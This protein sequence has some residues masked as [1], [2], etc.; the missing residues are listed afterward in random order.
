MK[1]ESF[2]T[3]LK[4]TPKYYDDS[5]FSKMKL[6]GNRGHF[7]PEQ[8]ISNRYAPYNEGINM[9]MNDDLREY[10]NNYQNNYRNFGNQVYDNN[11]NLPNNQLPTPY[12]VD[13]FSI[14]GEQEK[15][16]KMVPQNQFSGTFGNPPQKEYI[17]N[18]MSNDT[19]YHYR[20]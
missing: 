14:Q 7:Y 3:P 12:Q 11:Y 17:P 1:S 4:V 20:K 6:L 19:N 16:S 8:D 2:I 10:D 5:V 9:N 15:A 18:E 13:N